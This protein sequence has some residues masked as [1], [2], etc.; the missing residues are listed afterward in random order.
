MYDVYLSSLEKYIYHVHYVQII[1]KNHCGKLRQNT[2]YSKPGNILLIRDYAERISANLNIEIQ[3]DL[4][5]KRKKSTQRLLCNR[6]GYDTYSKL[7]I[8]Y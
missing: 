1:S 3:F 7:K 5:L 8:N 2:C 6:T 4:F